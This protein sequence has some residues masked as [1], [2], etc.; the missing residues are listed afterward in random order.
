[1]C[2]SVLPPTHALDSGDKLV[3]RHHRQSGRICR[4]TIRGI[5]GAQH[6]ITSNDVPRPKSKVT[7]GPDIPERHAQPRASSPSLICDRRSHF[8]RIALLAAASWFVDY[9]VGAAQ[10]TQLWRAEFGSVSERSIKAS[11]VFLVV[12][13]LRRLSSPANRRVGLRRAEFQNKPYSV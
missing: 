6:M 12:L 8:R 1:M 11:V 3:R 4:P 9:Q 7:R 2:S 13:R 5:E 10:P